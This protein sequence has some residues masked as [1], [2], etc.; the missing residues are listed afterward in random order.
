MFAPIAI[1][2]TESIA[3]LISPNPSRGNTIL[4]LRICFEGQTSW[5][6]N[7]KRKEE[8]IFSAPLFLAYRFDMLRKLQNLNSAP[9]NVMI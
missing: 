3:L 8:R 4:P 6:E 9:P 5:E 7:V 2:Q 1:P